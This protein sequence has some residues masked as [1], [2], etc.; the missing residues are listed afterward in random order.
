MMYEPGV[1]ASQLVH[2]GKLSAVEG[3]LLRPRGEVVRLRRIQQDES[4][5][6]QVDGVRLR[7]VLAAGARVWARIK[8]PEPAGA[9]AAAELM[10]AARE[11]PRGSSQQRRRGRQQVR[12]PG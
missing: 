11:H 10:V 4:E 2:L 5:L 7:I 6:A 8:Q 1:R 12:L 3:D 9:A